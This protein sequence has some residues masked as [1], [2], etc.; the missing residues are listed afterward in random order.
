MS[1]IST[2]RERIESYE[3]LTD[4]K[5]LKKLPVIIVLNGRSFK[6]STSLLEKPFSAQF[7]ELMCAT[8]IK[9]SQ[10]ID[11][12]NFVYSFNDEIIIVLRNDQGLNTEAWCNNKIQK[13]VS[14]SS[15]IATLEFN[16]I[17]KIN[18]VQLFG[19]PIFIAHT[20]VVP[21]I[22]EAINLLVSKQQQ[23]FHISL[24]MACFYELLKKYDVETV[25]Q[26]LIE[27]NASAKMDLLLEET[28]IEFNTYP[29][30]FRR[31]IAAYRTPTLMSDEIKHK[32]TIN[33]DVPLFS[34]EHE[35]LTSIFKSGKDIVRLKKND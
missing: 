20:F 3:D 33:M 27:K 2:L 11:G 4:V 31:G 21:N 13:I 22:N 19:D 15:S 30:P 14:T 9:L 25:K 17:A 29:I 12:T 32:L 24:Y 26:T 6:K 16:R 1:A 35:F 5:L 34:K 10:E 8:I 18:N 7:M 28:G 23:A